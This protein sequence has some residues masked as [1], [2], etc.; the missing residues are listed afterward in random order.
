MGGSYETHHPFDELGVRGSSRTCGSNLASD[1]CRSLT[2]VQ[3]PTAVTAREAAGSEALMANAK[4][5]TQLR[6][7]RQRRLDALGY[8]AL[9][10]LVVMI[11]LRHMPGF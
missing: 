1:R 5:W 3:A 10:V 4:H 7:R 2:R 11:T 8:A 6:T 9:V